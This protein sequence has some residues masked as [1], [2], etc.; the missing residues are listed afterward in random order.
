MALVHEILDRQQLHRRYSKRLQIIDHYPA[1]QSGISTAQMRRYVGVTHSK[2]PDMQFVDEGIVPR[3]ARWTIITPEK[4]SVGYQ[5]LGHTGCAVAGIETQI[6]AA[7]ANPV[8][9][10]GIAPVNLTDDGLGIRIKQQF[11][12]VKALT[13][14]WCMRSI[15]PI[16]VQQT[17]PGIRQITMPNPTGLLAQRNLCDFLLAARVE[18]TQHHLLG[19]C[20]EQCE[21]DAFTVPTCTERVRPA[22]P[23]GGG[24]TTHWLSFIASKAE[25]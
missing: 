6:F 22:G 19:M 1:S 18:Q 25:K 5:T 8:A 20:R 10:L 16:S 12:R 24:M 7:T 15:Y 17:R 2:T 21:I 13:F 4:S 11:V 3:G 23:Y 9:K 14:L